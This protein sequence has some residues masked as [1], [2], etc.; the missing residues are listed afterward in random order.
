MRQLTFLILLLLSPAIGLAGTVSVPNS[1]QANT[2][3]VAGQVNANFNALVDAINDLQAQVNAQQATISQ[4]QTDLIAAN[5]NLANVQANSVLSLDGFLTLDVDDNGFDT[6]R[7]DQVNVQ[8][9]N[10]LGATNGVPGSEPFQTGTVNGLGNLVIGYNES[11]NFIEICSIGSFL[12]Q[13]DC[14]NNGGTWGADQKT[15]SHNLVVGSRNSYTS[16][17]AI[18][19]GF[20]NSVNQVFGATVGGLNNLASGPYGSVVGGLGNFAGGA[21]SSVSGGSF[22]SAEEQ[23]SSVSGGTFNSAIGLDSSVSGGSN[24]IASGIESSVSGGDRREASGTR[25]WRA[26]SL[27]E[28]N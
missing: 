22:N 13:V 23:F 14:E 6:V 28:D 16:H 1:F 27:F 2:P 7:F 4:L 21:A 12:N 26:G 18:A 9:T 15:G 20:Q 24:N 8:I 10:G 3:A 25:D 5:A 11:G 19:A 17:G